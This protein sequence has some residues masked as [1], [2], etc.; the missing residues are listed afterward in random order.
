MNKPLVS[1]IVPTCNR[2]EM[3][4]RAVL[5]ILRQSFQ[6]FEVIIVD[7]GMKDR[8]EDVIRQIG[9]KRIKYIKNEEQQGAAKSRNIGIQKGTGKY[10]AFLDDDDEFLPEKLERQIIIMKENE[11]DFTF[12]AIELNHE[13]DGKVVKQSFKKT[14]INNYYEDLLAH[15]LRTLTSS[16]MIKKSVLESV[17]GFDNSF[18]SCQEWDLMIR[19]S[20]NHLGYGLNEILVRMNFLSGEHIGGS[21]DKRIAGRES[22]LKKH[23]V[24]LKR[25][26]KVLAYHYFYLGIFCRDNREMQ[27]ARGYFLK[28]WKEEKT[29][30]RYL[31]HYLSLLASG[32]LYKMYKH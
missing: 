29:N 7:D 28:S 18:K 3:L 2:P 25:R 19:I 31:F 26:P 5:S 6:D 9:D 4:R 8:A 10:I 11:I 32:F 21:L 23:F 13:S 22:L 20:R 12:C 14:G 15:K 30:V 1:V 16:L 27:R 17:F 24:E